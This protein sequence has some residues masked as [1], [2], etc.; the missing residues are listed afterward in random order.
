MEERIGTSV[1]MM[2][3]DNAEHD[4]GMHTTHTEMRLKKRTETSRQNTEGEFE[5]EQ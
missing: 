1:I 2:G 5:R 4:S 3:Q